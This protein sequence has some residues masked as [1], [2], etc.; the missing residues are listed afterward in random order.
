MYSVYR[1]VLITIP[2]GTNGIEMASVILCRGRILPEPSS[3]APIVTG[4]WNI[5]EDF[6]FPSAD[7]KTK[8]VT[9]D[10][11]QLTILFEELTVDTTYE[12]EL[13]VLDSGSNLTVQSI[14][15]SIDIIGNRF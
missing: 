4:D 9:V 10:E 1:N 6:V 3:G 13:G 5:C 11:D 12:L 14:I 7:A 8:A 2:V 15:F